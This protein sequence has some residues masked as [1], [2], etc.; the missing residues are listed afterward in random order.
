MSD[1]AGVTG[2]HGAIDAGFAKAKELFAEIKELLVF[3]F[4]DEN[5]FVH[6]LIG[7]SEFLF[8]GVFYEY[9]NIK[10]IMQN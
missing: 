4:G 5:E 8:K 9:Q 6:R 7:L 1:G 3:E 10:E 2:G